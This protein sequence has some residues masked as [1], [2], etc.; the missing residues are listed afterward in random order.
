LRVGTF[1]YARAFENGT[2]LKGLFEYAAKRHYPMTLKATNPP[3]EFLKVVLEKQL[4]LVCHWQRVGFIHGVMN[5]DNTTISG[6]T[7]DYGPCAFMDEFHPSTVFSSIDMQKRYAFS[8]QAPI[9]FW[10]LSR[11]AETLL[12]LINEKEE[13][14]L[15]QA[16]NILEQG[17]VKYHE[18]YWNMMA[19]KIGFLKGNDDIKSSIK[20]LLEV[21][22]LNK[23]DYTNTYL[24][25]ANK[26]SEP[27]IQL[28]KELTMWGD[29]WQE[30]L[31]EYGMQENALS[32]MQTNNPQ[33][34]PR[35][36]L[37]AKALTE[38]SNHNDQLF[39]QLLERYK[40]PYQKTASDDFFQAPPT[41]HEKVY[42]T[43]CG[44]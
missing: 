11:L 31:A 14:A 27:S 42:E 2:S 35:N 23:L 43:Y 38:L 24:T 30:K 12:P 22:Q 18:M 32:L 16:Q 36:H 37:V 28:P 34:I 25:L 29:D 4:R 15:E 44:T 41:A 33:V 19:Q 21:M 8:N 9:I 13:I 7:I 20:I 1:E 17:E 6:E 26:L 5:T 3:L 39:I 40:K 10:N